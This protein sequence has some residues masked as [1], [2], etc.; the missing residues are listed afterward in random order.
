MRAAIYAR[1]STD[2][3]REASIADQFRVAERLAEQHGFDVVARFSDAAI[4]AERRADPATSS[5][6][7]QH[8]RGSSR[9]SSARLSAG[10]GAMV[11]SRVSAS[12]NFVILESPSSVAMLTCAPKG[13][14]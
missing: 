14:I 10:C 3:Q 4:R 12:Q 1:F 2:K 9:R 11:P 13:R 5:C 7:N 6:S 8:A